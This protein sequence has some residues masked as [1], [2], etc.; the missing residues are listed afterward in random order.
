MGSGGVTPSLSVN[1]GGGGGDNRLASDSRYD[2]INEMLLDLASW[3][4]SIGMS[5]DEYWNGE[6]DAVIDYRRAHEKKLREENRLMHH[7]GAYVYQSMLAVAPAYNFWSRKR[8][9]IP[10]PSDPIP[11]LEEE[12]K[13]Q[14]AKKK[15]EAMNRLFNRLAKLSG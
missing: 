15:R 12:A 4:M 1:A 2:S 3:Y 7:F 6:A 9:P 14:E 13:E 5:R 8:E 11:I 10:Y